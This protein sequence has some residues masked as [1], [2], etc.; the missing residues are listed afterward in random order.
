MSLPSSA[1]GRVLDYGIFQFSNADPPGS[2]IEMVLGPLLATSSAEQDQSKSL[3]KKIAKK[4]YKQSAGLVHFSPGANFLLT[5]V[6][7]RLIV[8]RADSFQIT[9]TW[10]LDAS[11]PAPPSAKP[12]TSTSKQAPPEPSAISHAGWSCDSEY[13]LAACAKRGVVRV[14]KLRDEHWAARIDA[15]TEGL[16]RAEWAPDGRHILCFSEWGVSRLPRARVCADG[17]QLRVTVWSLVTGG[18][19]YIQFP[20]HPD[21]G[22][23]FRADGRYF[24]LA[25][26]HKAKDSLGVYDAA[27]AYKLARHFP[28]PTASVS[29]LAISP[30]GNHVAVWEGPL[31]YKLHILTLAGAPLATFTPDPDPGFGVRAVAWHPS[32][33]FLAVGGWD[34]RVHVLDSLTWGAV[35]TL[36]LAPRVPAGVALWREPP[37]WLDSDAARGFISYE[38]L[39]APQSIT[40][41]RPDLAKPAPKAGVVQLEW[42]K[43]GTLL[44]VR[45]ENVPTAV[46]IYAFPSL[47]APSANSPEAAAP[48]PYFQPRLRSVLLHTRPVLAA[49][50]NPLPTRAGA[51]AL[52]TGARSVYT[53]SDE[54]QEGEGGGEGEE[55]AE[56]IGVPARKF[57]TRD[58]R[59]APDGRGMVLVDRETFCCAFEVQEDE[60]LG[61]G[62]GV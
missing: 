1:A 61:G 44:L 27:E 15:G 4:I 57:E 41:L 36:E 5:A 13:I 22:Y 49:R 35:C 47:L 24:V 50:W 31:E 19:T 7:D 34:E 37:G 10:L 54:W 11:P 6:H 14:Y 59:W 33:A 32:G 46:H 25:E 2:A 29:N 60:A 52:C 8:R 53:W 39:R 17:G 21:R 38:K 12:S 48:A 18:A 28:L 42:N 26:R 23:A 16:V 43:T 40:P 56:C 58:V 9:R 20:V 45:F 62:E 51:L 55:L 30:T 3:A